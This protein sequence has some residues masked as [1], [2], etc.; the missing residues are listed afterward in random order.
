MNSLGINIYFLIELEAYV[1]KGV[2]LVLEGRISTPIQIFDAFRECNNYMS[3][4]VSDEKGNLK[5]IRFD[6]VNFM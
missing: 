2:P 6:K 3:D 4:Y 5:E 1:S